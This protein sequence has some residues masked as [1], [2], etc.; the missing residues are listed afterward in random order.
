MS[1]LSRRQLLA[2]AAAF[3]VAGPPGI[4]LPG[5]ATAGP[6]ARGCSSF[7]RTYPSVLKTSGQNLADAHGNVM[8]R[9]RGF[10]VQPVPWPQSAY[11]AMAEKGACLIRTVVFWDELEPSRGS[12][13][14]TY[15]EKK[16][17]VH[18]SRVRAARMYTVINFYFGPAQHTPGWARKQKPAACM[19]NYLDNG[20]FA[21]QY[22]AKR[23]GDPSDPLG[24]GQYTPV[25][26]G[27]GINEP[28]PDYSN[29]ADWLVHL[30]GQ[31]A[32][33]V[34]WFREYAPAW[35]ALLSC[36]FGATAPLPNAPGSGQGQAQ[37]F[38][39]APASPLASQGG[40]FMLDLH[41]Y[42]MATTLTT[43]PDFDGRQANGQTDWTFQGGHQIRVDSTGYPAYPPVVDGVTMKRGTCQAQQRAFLAP[44]ADYCAASY[45]D[46]PLCV[47]EWGWVPEDGS[48]RFSGGPDYITDKQAAWASANAAV[49]MQWDFNL[50][51]AHDPWAAHPG[52]GAA[53]ADHDG[54]QTVTSDF[55]ASCS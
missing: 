27:F 28:T 52:R 26:A 10:N 19:S 25:V 18:I 36:G 38:T 34:S 17:D 20:Q 14:P 9:M 37:W 30:L 33:E 54:W 23:Y 50:S 12:I 39:S 35:I 2:G 13:D 6:A 1:I 48:T 43:R 46:V 53:G 4:R 42:F 45:A 3:A 21:T 40:N 24:A 32:T 31:Q 49:E 47:G 51:R 15:I 7:P 16:L 55:F 5:L 44:Y 29:R 41:D 8:P 11:T 22:L